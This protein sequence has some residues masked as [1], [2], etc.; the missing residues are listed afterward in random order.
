M[1]KPCL[2]LFQPCGKTVLA[3][4]QACRFIHDVLKSKYIPPS[5]DEWGG[6]HLKFLEGDRNV[7]K[8]LPW[9][10]VLSSKIVFPGSRLALLATLLCHRLLF[11]HLQSLKVSSLPEQFY[12]CPLLYVT[13]LLYVDSAKHK[14]DINP[15]AKQYISSFSI[16]PREVDKSF[17][18]QKRSL[19]G[20][21]LGRELPN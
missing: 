13:C 8:F 15:K 1:L 9:T 4:F 21:G 19:L 10:S 3:L 5:P 16:P 6:C 2:F 14:P 18:E 17:T 7:I 11:H 20:A 12:S